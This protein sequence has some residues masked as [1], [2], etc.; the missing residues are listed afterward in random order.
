MASL[1]DL[2]EI[3]A[4]RRLIAERGAA[5]GVALGPGD[6][7]ALLEPT[8]ALALVATTDTFVEGT[9]YVP[10]WSEPARVGARLAAANLSDLAAMAAR[11]RWALL[12]IGARPDSTIDSLV[13]LQHGLA[14]AL[15]RHGAGIA[16]GNLTAVEDAEWFTLTLLGE[17]EAGRAWRRS[18]ARPGDKV[19]ITGYPGR[20]GA[21]LELSRTLGADAKA[22]AWRALLDAWLAPVARVPL[23]LDL[24]RTGA[25]RAAIDVSDG[26]AGDLAR[27][28]GASGVGATL[29]AAAWPRDADLERASIALGQ[30]LDTL[31]LGPSDDYELLL[32]ID[33]ARR[34]AAEEVARGHGVPLATI[35]RFTSERGALQIESETGARPI[36]ARGYDPF[37]RGSG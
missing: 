18:G 14:S 15:A 17:V 22:P 33:P 13:Q 19:A 20:A 26:L 12:T 16:G 30:D 5:S 25:V 9:H 37:E 6:D 3:E 34:A 32:A 28:C 1:R 29:S 4:V 10:A 24:A 8:A 31:R 36:G 7:A 35:G 2:G 23:A 11:P 21:G 27:V